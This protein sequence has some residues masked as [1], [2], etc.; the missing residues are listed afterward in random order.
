MSSSA[1][2][3][4]R[5]D[6]AV[7]GVACRLPGAPDPRALWR[8]L[9]DGGDA[10]T[11]AP[12]GRWPGDGVAVRR[13]G[14]LDDVAGFDPEFFG[15]T[16]REA[17]AMDP[18]QRLMLELCWEALEDAGIVPES[19]RATPL[20]VFAGA[21]ADDY[22]KL[23]HRHG[24]AVIDQHTLAGVSR[25]LLAN[26]VS[27]LLGAT[28]PSLTVDTGQSSSLAAVHLAVQSL[29]RGESA[30]A[31]AGGVNLNLLAESTVVV[32]RFGGLSPDGA[33]FTFDARANGYV[34]GR[35]V[36]WCCS[37]PCPPRSRTATTCTA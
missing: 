14:F 6:V 12:P 8:L 32:D 13:G 17:R 20:G 10:I 28:G 3:T 5:V 18:Q 30:L 27:Y 33:S 2:G 21:M 25:A 35:A 16:A 23:V 34:R 29:R 19:L 1:E 36:A 9:R 31:L 26:R 15:L 37:S 7:V 4:A 24:P 11:E 22:A